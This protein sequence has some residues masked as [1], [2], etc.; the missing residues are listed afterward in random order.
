VAAAD[1]GADREEVR[2]EVVDEGVPDSGKPVRPSRKAE[3]GAVP[4]L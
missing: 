2:A 3:A 1:T 4:P